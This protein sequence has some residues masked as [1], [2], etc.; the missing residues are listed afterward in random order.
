MTWNNSTI[1]KMLELEDE[2]STWNSFFHF[3][4]NVADFYLSYESLLEPTGPAMLP[5]V[6]TR[7]KDYMKQITVFLDLSTIPQNVPTGE[8]PVSVHRDRSAKSTTGFLQLHEPTCS[9]RIENYVEFRKHPKV[10]T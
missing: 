1:F 4:P 10:S 7:K 8:D 9:D 5:E 3:M 6:K 2:T